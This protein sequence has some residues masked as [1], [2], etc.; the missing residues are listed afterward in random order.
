MVEEAIEI[1]LKQHINVLY[2]DGSPTN[3]KE[4][5]EWLAFKAVELGTGNHSEYYYDE[6]R[7][8][9]ICVSFR[10]NLITLQRTI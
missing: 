9:D 3:N 7:N 6:E 1:E 5:K 8:E 4:F 2:I 10:V